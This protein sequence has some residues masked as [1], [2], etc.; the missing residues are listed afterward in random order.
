MSRSR[1]TLSGLTLGTLALAAF[2]LGACDSWPTT[3]PWAKSDAAAPSQQAAAPAPT[4]GL[5]NIA[6]QAGTPAGA[7]TTTAPPTTS[8]VAAP[9]APPPVRDEAVPAAP[10]AG[11]VWIPGNW[12]FSGATW[13]WV[14]GRYETPPRPT[15]QWIP[16]HWTAEQGGGG[17]WVWV[18]GRWTG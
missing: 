5:E 13:A 7:P 15:A 2:A 8:V 9:M 3:W 16:G 4:S 17:V 11:M 1:S 12:N 14:P 6:P 10:A 18:S